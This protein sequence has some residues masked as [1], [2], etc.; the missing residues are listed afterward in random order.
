MAT[1]VATVLVG[2]ASASVAPLN[3]NY[4]NPRGTLRGLPAW[5]LDFSTGKIA[6]L[7]ER[8]HL[9]FIGGLD[10]CVRPSFIR[11]SNIR[12]R[13]DRAWNVRINS[14]CGTQLAAIDSNRV[15]AGVLNKS[16]V[17]NDWPAT[18]GNF[19]AG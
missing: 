1:V 8:F 6:N 2:A 7:T 4:A 13:Y 17:N 9:I 10:Q 5:Q 18:V 12:I 19:V 15:A 14:N 16:A 3:P 11:R